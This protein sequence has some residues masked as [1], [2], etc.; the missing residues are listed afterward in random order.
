MIHQ[1]VIVVVMEVVKVVVLIL[2]VVVEVVELQQ[3]GLKQHVK[4]VV[5][6]EQEHQTIF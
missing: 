6:V 1:K 4:M 5:Q 3:M 2:K